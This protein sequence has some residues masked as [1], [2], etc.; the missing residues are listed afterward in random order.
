MAR[1]RKRKKKQLTAQN[2]KTADLNASTQNT[3]RPA[4]TQAI[5]STKVDTEAMILKIREEFEKELEDERKRLESLKDTLKKQHFRQKAQEEALIEKEKIQK[6]RDEEQD[7]RELAQARRDEEQDQRD[8]AQ[9]Q[10]HVELR[11]REINAENGFAAERDEMLETFTSERNRLI[12]EI[13]AL[14]NDLANIRE[15]HQANLDAALQHH[16]EDAENALRVER[17][18]QDALFETRLTQLQREQETLAERQRELD[19]TRRQLDFDR[20]D[21]DDLREHLEERAGQLAARRI[22]VLEYTLRTRDEE[23]QQARADRDNNA[24]MLRERAEADRRFGQRTP[25]EVI[26]EIDHLR[27]ECEELR[28]K[29]RQ[30]L[31][32]DDQIRLE[33][34]IEEKRQWDLDRQELLTR[35]AELTRRVEY[36]RLQSGELETQRDVIE[37][38]E[39][40]R[41]LLRE[42]NQQ[43]RAEIDDLIARSEAESAFPACAE[44]DSNQ[45]LQ[46][47]VPMFR[48]TLS[49][50]YFVNDLQH[51]IA[52]TNED[53]PLFYTQEDLRAFLGGLAMGHLLLLQGISGTG[54]TS[55]P[56]AFAQAVGG[57]ASVI[58]VQAGW[59]DPQDLVGHYN[60]FEK[61][62]HEKEFL[63]AI[64]KAQTPRW[65]D[66]LHIVLLDEMNLSHPEQYFSDMLSTLERTPNER[67]LTITT[68]T[69]GQPPQLFLEG[70]KL[71]IPRNVWFVGTANHD[72][73]TKNFADKTYDRSHVQE[74]PHQPTPFSVESV[75]PRDPISFDA[76]NKAF[77]AAIQAHANDAERA[78]DTL[79]DHL[80][81]PL[82]EHFGIGWGPRLERQLNR[83]V[84][85]VVAAGGGLGEALDHVLATRL[86]RKLC[87]RHDNRPE[88][89]QDLKETILMV[90][91]D[92]DSQPN[93]SEGLLNQELKRL[94]VEI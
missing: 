59:R 51:R 80:R 21:V 69:V 66:A 22:E 40:Q 75:E 7:Q 39:G 72:E 83:Y 12:V 18:E 77:E 74:F 53:N 93:K 29:L 63:Q 26:E 41:E 64:Y 2:R 61:R 47:P 57:S 27:N 9:N 31:S 24:Q 23:L 6:K 55:L 54:K 45:T 68:H 38:L 71:R 73:T 76:L 35:Q 25:D 89:L 87:Y 46:Q 81:D 67:S 20:E 16:R 56:L 30:R 37:S 94:G 10:R 60:N 15:Q 43:V 32:D 82:T 4:S 62:F 78:V 5:Q 1:N 42:A 58:E 70:R 33:S 84:S 49:L 79:N 90:W 65:K 17:E 14:R 50:D 8:G 3:T 52:R 85:V 88:H 11:Q 91:D 86:I 36:A 19:R 44:M 34:L 48:G 13:A 28:Q 92:F